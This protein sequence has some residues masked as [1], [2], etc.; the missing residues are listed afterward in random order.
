MK[1]QEKIDVAEDSVEFKDEDKTFRPWGDYPLEEQALKVYTLP[2][3]L[4]FRAELRKVTSY[5]VQH[6]GGDRKSVV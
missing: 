4:R 1:L 2:I 5:N 6:V 3:Y